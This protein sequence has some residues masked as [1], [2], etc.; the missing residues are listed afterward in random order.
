M[1]ASPYRRL[2]LVTPVFDDWESFAL[3]VR[4][5]DG[6]YAKAD[7]SVRVFAVDDGSTVS[8]DGG[9]IALAPDGCIIGIEVIHLAINV[10]HQ[11]AIAI[12]LA[13]LAERDDIDAVVVMDCDGEDRPADILALVTT[14]RANSDCVVLAKRAKRTE[15]ATFRVFYALF[16]AFFR[17]LTGETVDFGNFSLIPMAGVRRLVHMGDLW[18]NL[19][20]SIMRSR[21][22]FLRVPTARGRRYA[23]ESKMN[24]MALV[25]HGMSA[26][27]VFTE[28]IFVR[29]LVGSILVAGVTLVGIVI[30]TLIRLTT[31]LAIPGWATTVVGMLVVV[32]VQIISLVAVTA[33][34]V[35]AGRRSRPMIPRLEAGYLIAG[36]D[37]VTLRRAAANA[38]G[39]RAAADASVDDGQ[40]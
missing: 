22:A 39:D 20:I 31:D 3:L 5:I 1:L 2:A 19:P 15:S 21:L 12:G 6:V 29:L 34:M 38:L 17:I 24:F 36:I 10:G 33:L 11:R 35:L 40:R 9:S 23:G 27:S 25:I 37:R 30:A 26:M 13:D 28:V 8:F 14:A 16:K 4:E 18:N 7:F 32:L